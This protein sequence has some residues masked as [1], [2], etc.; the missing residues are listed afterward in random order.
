MR[1]VYLSWPARE[2]AGGIKLA[3]R[4][5]ECLRENNIDAIVAT[6]DGVGPQ[7]FTADT[8]TIRLNE[9]REHHDILVFPENHTDFLRQFANWRNPKVVFCQN[10]FMAFRGVAG[11]RCYG[12]FGVTHILAVGRHVAEFCARRFPKLRISSIP[13]FVDTE[14]FRSAS[15]KQL[16]IVFAPRKRPQEAEFIRDLFCAENPQWAHVPWVLLKGRNEQGVAKV[17]AESTNYLSLCRFEAYPLSILEAMASGCIVAGFTGFGARNY[18]TS[19]NGF[20][21]EEDD[22]LDCVAQLAKAVQLVGKTEAYGEMVSQAI[23]VAQR[24]RKSAFTEKLIRFWSGF[25]ESSNK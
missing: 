1:I 13:A 14:T 17:L 9:T 21:A 19:A 16:A 20:W 7:W 8:P 22:C 24:H 5:V 23:A 15:K 12:N 2:I 11:D 25:L 3:Y 4:S 10:Q 18:T 6:P